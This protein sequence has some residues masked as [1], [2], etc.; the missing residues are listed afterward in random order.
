MVRN[1]VLSAANEVAQAMSSRRL[2][3]DDPRIA[4]IIIRSR[5]WLL[6]NLREKRNH[7]A[8]QEM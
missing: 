1:L 7:A 2:K 4:Q 6:L 3:V 8:Y 5:R